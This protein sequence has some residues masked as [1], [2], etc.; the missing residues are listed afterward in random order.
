LR[1]KLGLPPLAIEE[2]DE[3][4]IDPEREAYENY[5]RQKE[6]QERAKREEEAKKKSER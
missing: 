2:S 4:T 3:E 6:D 5:Q 1:A